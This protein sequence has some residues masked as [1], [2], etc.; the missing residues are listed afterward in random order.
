MTYF[1]IICKNI[2]SLYNNYIIKK[3]ETKFDST[4]YVKKS[5]TISDM[6]F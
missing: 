4:L 1:K 3:F 6:L 2:K 5:L